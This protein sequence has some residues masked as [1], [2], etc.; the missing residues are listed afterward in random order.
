MLVLTPVWNSSYIILRRKVAIGL[1]HAPAH[2]VLR[3]PR[4]WAG[5]AH[6]TGRARTAGRTVSLS[7]S[8]ELL[9]KGDC[10]LC[11]TELVPTLCAINPISLDIETFSV[12]KN[13][14]AAYGSGKIENMKRVAVCD[15]NYTME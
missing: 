9:E 5:L 14:Y 10:E 11:S 12:S 4:A 2:A 13:V 3:L 6:P 1:C 8:I 15:G 7:R